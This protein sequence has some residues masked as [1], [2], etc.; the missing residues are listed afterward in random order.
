M[1][2]KI[3]I[4]SEFG[5]GTK[6]TFNFNFKIQ[7]TPFIKD[8]SSKKHKL[9]TLKGKRALLV[10]DNELNREIAKDILEIEHIIVDEATNG[11]EAVEIIKTSK[12]GLYDF[13]LMDVQMPVID[14]YQATDIIRKLDNKKLANIPIIAMTANAFEEDKKRALESGMDD[15]LSK[16]IRAETLFNTV[17][18]I[19]TKKKSR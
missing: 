18:Q 2:G 17:S 5:K 9:V 7:K 15:Y 4:E 1:K 10:E 19:L 8:K 16:P 13:I 6:V 14:G 3:Y 12:P 11:S